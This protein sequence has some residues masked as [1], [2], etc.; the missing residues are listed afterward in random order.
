[1]AMA[2]NRPPASHPPAT[3]RAVAPLPS[4]S[5]APS[6]LAPGP[7]A[8]RGGIWRAFNA[9]YEKYVPFVRRFLSRRRELVP[10]S[11]EDLIQ[12][13]FTTV[14]EQMEKLDAPLANSRAFIVKIVGHEVSNHARLRRLPLEAEDEG[15]AVPCSRPDPE[16]MAELDER[17][18][19][20]HAH[21]DAMEEDDA[22]LIRA[23]DLL[24]LTY[25]EVGAIQ[26]RSDDAVGD[27][28]RRARKIL[29]ERLR[30]AG[31]GG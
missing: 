1:M 19:N 14:N 9:L 13:A 16:R 28:Y 6:L 24:G 11:V 25:V 8:G 17:A 15:L 4:A 7:L 20:L 21:L 5:D 26:G 27:Q 10:A 12:K 2:S 31:S 18:D 23:V 29:N 22:N 30:A 3:L